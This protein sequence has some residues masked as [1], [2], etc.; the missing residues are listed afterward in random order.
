L[1]VPVLE[2]KHLEGDDRID[3][4]FFAEIAKIDDFFSHAALLILIKSMI[5]IPSQKIQYSLLSLDRS[6][7]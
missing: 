3:G 1:G 5:N 7:I 2:L 6:Q 4:Y